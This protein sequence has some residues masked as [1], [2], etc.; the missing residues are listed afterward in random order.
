[1]GGGSFSSAPRELETWS[2]KVKKTFQMNDSHHVVVPRFALPHVFHTTLMAAYHSWWM[3]CTAL[4]PFV[5]APAR[6][7]VRFTAYKC[8]HL[9]CV[10]LVNFK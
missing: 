5:V 2:Q 9:R 1:M 3:A 4:P 6:A 8:F 10:F 7:A